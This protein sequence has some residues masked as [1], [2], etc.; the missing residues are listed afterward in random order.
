[1]I[2]IASSFV[3]RVVGGNL[4]AIAQRGSRPTAPSAAW[5]ARLSTFTT[6]PSMS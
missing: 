1:L 2:S 4:K 6:A 3:V 5:R